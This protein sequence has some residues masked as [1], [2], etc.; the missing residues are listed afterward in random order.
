MKKYVKPNLDVY[1]VAVGDV[2]M[3][4]GGGSNE[5]INYLNLNWLKEI[6]G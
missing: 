3:V 5:I 6:L 1:E 4:S 2:L